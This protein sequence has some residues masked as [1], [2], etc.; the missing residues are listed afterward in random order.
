VDKDTFTFFI[1]PGGQAMEQKKPDKLMKILPSFRAAVL[2][3]FMSTVCAW[4]ETT[5]IP[6]TINL[7]AQANHP[8]IKDLPT[9][10]KSVNN[11]THGKH[12][13]QYLKGNSA[14]AAKSFTDEFTC[15]ACH[16]E[17]AS[18]EAITDSNPQERVLAA[19]NAKGGPQ[20]LKNYF[21]DICLSCHKSM[22][23]AAISTGPTTCN[24][25]HSRK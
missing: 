13:N 6:D 2:F 10:A 4:A 16:L 23:K 15:A 20:K 11:F 9:D 12:A 19:L 17:A 14:Y 7:N 1:Q 3:V 22:K 18:I 21:H 24:D 25:C 5:T 8:D